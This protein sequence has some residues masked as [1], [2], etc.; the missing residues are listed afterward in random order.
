MFLMQSRFSI[1][2]HYALALLLFLLPWQTRYILHQTV[3]QDGVWEYGTIGIYATE[4][5]LWGTAVWYAISRLRKTKENTAHAARELCGVRISNKARLCLGLFALWFIYQMFRAQF[6][7]VEAQALIHILEAVMVWYLI[8]RARTHARFLQWSFLAGLGAQ[9]LLALTQFFTQRAFVFRWLGITDHPAWAGGSAVIETISGRWL[10]AYGGLPHP[11]ILG[12]YMAVGALLVAVQI[13]KMPRE[14]NV[15]D[16]LRITILLLFFIVLVAGL[17]VSFSR[18]AMLALIC[19]LIVVTWQNVRQ[20]LSGGWRVSEAARR[21]WVMWF[22]VVISAG[23]F[24]ALVPDIFLTRARGIARL[25]QQSISER[26]ASYQ[27]A[28]EVARRDGFLGTGL[29][30]YTAI[31]YALDST[32][33]GWEYQPVHN[34]LVLAF[35]EFGLFVSVVLIWILFSFFR[36]IFLERD[37]G[38]LVPLIVLVM[39]D[40]YIWS[41]WSGLLLSAV[42][43]A[44]GRFEK[45]KMNDVV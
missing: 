37:W 30:N 6:P 8:T 38:F 45:L 36:T 15:R 13:L 27:G 7:W 32:H 21:V 26:L 2:W 33:P 4:I 29:G 23:F 20:Q 28:R 9:A 19:G 3:W 34:A 14:K 24:V 11:N 44:K 1:Q 18:S 35:L 10:R 17:M 40:H 16:A 12:G 5:L 41:L 39:F 22:C 42:V 31:L 43:F 25:E